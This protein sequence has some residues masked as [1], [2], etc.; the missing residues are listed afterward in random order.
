M[1]TRTKILSVEI[2]DDGLVAIKLEKQVIL[3]GEIYSKQPHRTSLA[4]QTHDD[5]TP[6]FHR[7]GTPFTPEE[8]TAADRAQIEAVNSHLT[9]M[10][11]PALSS[12]DVAAIEA[13]VAELRQP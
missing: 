2:D 12:E 10:E 3:A 9:A 1:E 5:G 13:R 7:D 11:F 8:Q 6:P 4:R